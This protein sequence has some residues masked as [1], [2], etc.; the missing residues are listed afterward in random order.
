MECIDDREIEYPQVEEH[1]SLDLASCAS[2]N[3]GK[4][5]LKSQ[6]ILSLQVLSLE[7]TYRFFGTGTA[8]LKRRD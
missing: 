4:S 5:F 6:V 3:Q 7:E 2:P 8:I 1:E